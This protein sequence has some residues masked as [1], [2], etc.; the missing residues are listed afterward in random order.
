MIV[1]QN[2]SSQDFIRKMTFERVTLNAPSTIVVSITRI[3]GPFPIKDVSQALHKLQLKHPLTRS[4]IMYD[5]NDIAWFCDK[6]VPEIPCKIVPRESKTSWESYLRN[7]YQY[8]FEFSKGP[9]LRFIIIHSPQITEIIIFAHHTI[10]DGISLLYLQRDFLEFISNLNTPINPIND[11]PIIEEKNLPITLKNKKILVKVANWL[12]SKW[13]QTKIRF[14]QEDYN[15]LYSRFWQEPNNLTHWSLTPLQSER[16][17]I[18]SKEHGLKVHSV[19]CT[20]FYA[21]QAK[22]EGQKTPYSTLIMPLSVRSRLKSPVGEVCGFYATAAMFS[23]K[24]RFNLSFLENAKIFQKRIHHEMHKGDPFKTLKFGLIYPTLIDALYFQKFGL[25]NNKIARMLVKLLK[26]DQITTG[27]MI[28]NLGKAPI[29]KQYGNLYIDCI[30]AP[31]I[32]TSRHEKY[33]GITTIGDQIH[34]IMTSRESMVSSDKVKQI[35]EEAMIIIHNS[36][37][38]S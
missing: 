8:P 25:F 5:E 12:N 33:L 24:Y 3:Q 17:I 32:I 2:S 30:Y 35:C 15:E 16:L 34:F 10:S 18:W 6:K 28:S 36:Y 9:L 14:S 26:W 22:I 21:A 11:L 20:A 4:K 1:K 31:S 27:M 29:P 13:K 23:V 7:E 38:F 19:L 37:M